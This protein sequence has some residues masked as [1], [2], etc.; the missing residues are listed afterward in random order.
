MEMPDDETVREM[1]RRMGGYHPASDER[2]EQ[3]VAI[4]NGTELPLEL[5]KEEDLG[6]A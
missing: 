5:K 2:A 3:H 6:N 4:N 1:A